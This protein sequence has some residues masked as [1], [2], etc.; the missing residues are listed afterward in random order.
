MPVS[1]DYDKK[2]IEAF[3]R[4]WKLAEL[5][6]F[7]SFYYGDIHEKSDI[8]VLVEWGPDAEITFD[9]WYDMRIELETMFGREIDLVSKTALKNPYR[10]K[11]ILENR[12]VLYEKTSIS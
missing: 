11:E 2:Q 8:D 1:L 12:E 10:K 7:G 4:K 6:I 9:N 3:C 5:S